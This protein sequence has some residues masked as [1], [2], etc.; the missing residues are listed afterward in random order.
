MFLQVPHVEQERIVRLETQQ[1]PH[2]EQERIIRP[3]TTGASFGTGT[4]C[5]SRD[6]TGAT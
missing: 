6:T 3:E 2:V 1:V 5:P 4:D